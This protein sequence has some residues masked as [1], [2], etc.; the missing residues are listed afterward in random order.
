MGKMRKPE[1]D[2]IRGL[3]P[4]IAIEQKVNTRNP[5][6]TVGTTTEI[7][8]YLRLLFGRAG[9]TFSPV[10]GKEV[11]CHTVDDI[12]EAVK[13]YPE[14]TRLVVAA[15]VLVPSD[16]AVA[17][18]LALYLSAGYSRMV[19]GDGSMLSI[20][21]VIAANPTSDQ[22]PMLL[23]DRLAVEYDGDEARPTGRLC[24]DG[25]FRGGRECVA[26]YLYLPR[27]RSRAIGFLY[28]V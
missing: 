1:C 23:I 18:H 5:R 13:S 16:R 8:D 4:A 9:H 14:G 2:L 24:R 11:R 6:S 17:D 25:S 28:P 26:P 15:P 3:P 22:L 12:S 7:Y 27:R 21:E 20:E 10:T 19:T